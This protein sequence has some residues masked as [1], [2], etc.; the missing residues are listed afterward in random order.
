MNVVVTQSGEKVN[1]VDIVLPDDVSRT[2]ASMI[3]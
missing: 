1:I 2:I 3:G